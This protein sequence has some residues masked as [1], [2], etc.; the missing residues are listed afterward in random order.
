MNCSLTLQ[1]I[2][3]SSLYAMGFIP[4]VLFLTGFLL[5][6]A[7]LSYHTLKNTYQSLHTL[8]EALASS[9]PTY[10][11]Q[12]EALFNTLPANL[13]EKEVSQALRPFLEKATSTQGFERLFALEQEA[14]GS[15]QAF[16]QVLYKKEMQPSE[17]LAA[18]LTAWK[19]SEKNI[20]TLKKRYLHTQKSYGKLLEQAPS[21]WVA[22]LA[23]FPKL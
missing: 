19:E 21:A 6:S 23:S 7:L 18:A 17:A 13:Q 12:L 15:I 2:Y 9:L 1:K 5:L 16:K 11:Q 3:T 14:F 22:R 20:F 10:W 4:I 8:R